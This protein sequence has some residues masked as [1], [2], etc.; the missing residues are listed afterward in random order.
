TA[1]SHLPAPHGASRSPQ[2][3]FNTGIESALPGRDFHPAVCVRSEA[4]GR[5][6]NL[7]LA[8]QTDFAAVDYPEGGLSPMRVED[9]GGGRVVTWEAA[10]L[11][12]HQDMGVVVPEK[13]N[14][15]PLAAR[16]IFFAPV[17]LIFLFLLVVTINIVS[18]VNIHPMHYLFV[19]A[20][21]FAFHILLAYLVDVVNIHIAFWSAAAASLL[22]VNLYLRGTLG[23]SYPWKRSA[24][25]QVF[26][27]VLFSYS[28]FLKGMTGLTVAIGSVITLAVL[29]GIAAR[30]DWNGVFA[31]KH[32]INT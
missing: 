1:H 28:F 2:L 5:A 15:G 10:D 17:C 8:V 21:F 14:P 30:V 18:R 31:S 16:I 3:G 12:T 19:A 13:L 23:R 24:A 4:H 29:M 25:S 27:M 20:G 9:E 22:L 26:F 6:Q 7:R 32:E 11:I